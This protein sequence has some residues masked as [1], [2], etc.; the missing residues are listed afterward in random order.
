MLIPKSA[1]ALKN[2]RVFIWDLNDLASKIIIDARCASINEG[3]KRSI[4]AKKSRYEPSWRLIVHCGIEEISSPC[5]ICIV[6]HLVLRH[7]SEHGTRRMG[8]QLVAKSKIAKMN[9]ST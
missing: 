5:I 6:S 3:S 4:A 2:Q 8:K 9:K 1:T 7:P